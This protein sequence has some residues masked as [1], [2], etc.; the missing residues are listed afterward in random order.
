M[1]HGSIQHDLSLELAFSHCTFNSLENINGDPISTGWVEHSNSSGTWSG[2][3]SI[4]SCGQSSP[5]FW[6]WSSRRDLWGQHMNIEYSKLQ[7]CEI[8]FAVSGYVQ[9]WK[10]PKFSICGYTLY[11]ERSNSFLLWAIL[12]MLWQTHLMPLFHRQCIS[13]YMLQ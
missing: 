5:P 7:L 6:N 11:H 1:C 2:P 8:L 13:V 12:A 9:S 4:Q 3:R 10:C